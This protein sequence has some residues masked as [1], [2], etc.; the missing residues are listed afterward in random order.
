MM[1]RLS[2]GGLLL[3]TLLTLPVRAQEKKDDAPRPAAPPP[4]NALMFRMMDGSTISGRLAAKDLVVETPYGILHIPV[5]D[6]RHFTPGLQSHPDLQEK[7][8]TLVDRLGSSEFADRDAAQRDLTQM[9]AAIH[10]LLSQHLTD[11]DPERRQ[12]LQAILDETDEAQA[13]DDPDA[14]RATPWIALD[15]VETPRFTVRGKIAAQKFDLTTAYGPLTVQ[16]CDIRQAQSAAPAGPEIVRKTVEVANTNTAPSALKATSL[17]L[18]KGDRVTISASGQI[19]LPN[20]N[21]GMQGGPEGLPNMQWYERNKIPCCALVGQ[22]GKSGPLF[23]VG[24]KL[25]FKAEQAGELSLGIAYPP[26]MGT[27]NIVGQFT[28]KITV[29]AKP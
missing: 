18:Q 4:V 2:L 17:R 6:V 11:S 7:I 16:L 14:A 5:A 24:N 23:K 12:R 20:W 28:A 19:T 22:V 3:A 21:S 8:N 26:N 15:T 25:S 13:D 27:P 10:G 9:G 29:D 1:H